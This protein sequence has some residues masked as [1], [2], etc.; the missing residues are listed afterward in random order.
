MSKKKTK[1]PKTLYKLL[2]LAIDDIKR[3]IADENVSIDMDDWLFRYDKE[4]TVCL[5]GAV[6]LKS[7]DGKNYFK[8]TDSEDRK[9]DALDSIRQ[10]DIESA[11]RSLY[12]HKLDCDELVELTDAA[13][14]IESVLNLREL[15]EEK[16]EQD[17][18][19]FSGKLN[20]YEEIA[21]LAY[22]EDVLIELDKY[23]L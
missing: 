20:K 16:T 10:G 3:C 18:A 1:L 8:L 13:L 15:R 11:V 12:S 19:L 14:Q 21:L 17:Q 7:L 6:M 2:A 4:C 5:A 9:M 22:L 23:K